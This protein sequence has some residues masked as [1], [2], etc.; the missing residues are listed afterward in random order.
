MRELAAILVLIALPW[1]TWQNYSLANQIAAASAQHD[2]ELLGASIA[3]ATESKR[4][5]DNELEADNAIGLSWH[6]ATKASLER[7]RAERC[8]YQRDGTI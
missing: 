3:I 4:A 2:S 7:Y 1:L 6:L 5:D 8:E